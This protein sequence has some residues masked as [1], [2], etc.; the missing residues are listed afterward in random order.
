LPTLALS[1]TIATNP[2]SIPIFSA[3]LVFPSS[4]LPR[5]KKS[6]RT[7]DSS[8][9]YLDCTAPAAGWLQA[10]AVTSN[11]NVSG[12]FKALRS[13][14][15][16]ISWTWGRSW[17]RYSLRIKSWPA[18][19]LKQKFQGV[20]FL[21]GIDIR[22]TAPW[23]ILPFNGFEISIDIR[24]RF[25]ESCPAIHRYQRPSFSSAFAP[26]APSFL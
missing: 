19:I 1:V 9:P 8:Q 21:I 16:E 17:E 15:R 10:R 23:D 25:Q 14:D 20:E 5:L 12:K 26:P 7:H 3:S 18:R 2:Y 24:P 13:V 4:H 6:L 11:V 22:F